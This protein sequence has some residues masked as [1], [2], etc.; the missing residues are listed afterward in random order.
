[1]RKRVQLFPLLALIIC[2][3]IGLSS[4]L[5]YTDVHEIIYPIHVVLMTA[6]FYLV[7]FLLGDAKR[8]AELSLWIS[9]VALLLCFL[10]LYSVLKPGFFSV[11]NRISDLARISAGIDIGTWKHADDSYAGLA[12]CQVTAFLTAVTLYLYETGMP[13][14]VTAVPSFFVFMLPIAIDGV[15]YE[16]CF[17]SYGM[18]MIV[19]LGMGRRGES[20]RK[21][22]LLLCS[23]VLVGALAA[24]LLPWDQ[25]NPV[26]KTYRDKVMSVS[27]GNGNADSGTGSGKKDK[28]NEKENQ[29]ID[30]GQFDEEG[31]ITYNGT[32]ELYLSTHHSF[33]SQELFLRGF[34]G[35]TFENNTWFGDMTY[36]ADD[37]YGNAFDG[38]EDIAVT[39]GFDTGTYVLFSIDQKKYEKM[40]KKRVGVSPEN[41]SRISKSTQKVPESVKKRI[42][43]EILPKEM[44][45][46]V[47]DAVDFVKDY[48]SRGYKYTL[49]PGEVRQGQNEI[50]TFLFERKT[51]YCTHFASSAVMIFRTMGIPARL[52]QGYVVSGYRILPNEVTRVYDSN[53]H[54]WTEIYIDGEGWV[55]VEVTPQTDRVAVDEN[56]EGGGM[57]EDEEVAEAPVPA[58]ESDEPEVSQETEEK[59]PDGESDDGEEPEE[60]EDETEEEEVAVAA[61]NKMSQEDSGVPYE[62]RIAARLVLAFLIL[63]VVILIVRRLCR[64]ICYAG[65]KKKLQ[66]ENPSQRIT[67]LNEGMKKVWEGIGVQWSYSD[68]KKMTEHI[69]RNTLKYYI[70]RDAKEAE[71]LQRRISDYVFCVY[72]A[73][74]DGQVLSEEEYKQCE[75]YLSDFFAAMERA[76]ERKSWKKMN[77]YPVVRLLRKKR[78]KRK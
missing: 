48:F 62:L 13:G 58:Q 59:D 23:S 36:S 24:F 51:G 50:V 66:E 32:V 64:E 78:G 77:K 28:E 39:E 6:I 37:S 67:Y 49:R 45:V 75:D 25:V 53:A 61:A 68:S 63:L 52:A 12:M 38:E 31:N 2:S 55:P 5:Y 65:M 15:P 76:V 19:F 7:Y 70:F 16:A 44:P 27:V 47:N 57:A 11:F 33:T 14:F 34:I 69:F 17:I 35:R 22:V 4:G 43:K 8:K 74:Y 9:L 54:A 42:K 73:R 26:V 40:L 56:A 21:L 3:G 18:A 1:M 41:Q 29:K 46:S 60:E 72:R 30:F 20:I 71:E 10:F